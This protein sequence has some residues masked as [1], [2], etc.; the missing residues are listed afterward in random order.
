[1]NSFSLLL[2]D[3]SFV[4]LLLFILLF[5]LFLIEV[6]ACVYRLK[7]TPTRAESAQTWQHQHIL[8]HNCFTFIH[9]QSTWLPAEQTTWFSLA[10]LLIQPTR[11]PIKFSVDDLVTKYVFLPIF[12]I[13]REEKKER[14]IE[15]CSSC[16]VLFV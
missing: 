7:Y 6:R 9:S 8:P 11:I 10:S 4:A 5:F 14:Q 12:F 2:P 15:S 3:F 1:M 13:L 16:F